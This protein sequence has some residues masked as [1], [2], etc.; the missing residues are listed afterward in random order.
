MAPRRRLPWRPRALA[1]TCDHVVG[2]ALVDLGGQLDELGVEIVLPGLPGQVVR[3]DRDA[4]AADARARV[5]GMKP[6]GLLEAASITSQMS[7]PMRS[8]SRASSLTRAM[9]TLRKMF[10]SSLVSSAARGRR[11]DADVRRDVLQQARRP[12]ARRPG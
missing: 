9:L 5:K 12:V 3:I 7:M 6:K 1:T 8:Q 4:V 2:H 10:S 11:D